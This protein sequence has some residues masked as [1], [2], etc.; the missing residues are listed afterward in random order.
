VLDFT[1]AG[2]A[3]DDRLDVSGYGFA[4]LAAIAK[5]ASGDDALL[6]L[7]GGNT[8]LLVDYLLGHALSD[9]KGD[10]FIL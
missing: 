9:L 5:S 8:I 10:D 2:G 7:G 6:T 3:Q 1:D 4:S